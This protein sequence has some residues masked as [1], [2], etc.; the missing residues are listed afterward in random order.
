MRGAGPDRAYLCA[1]LLD[2]VSPRRTVDGAALAALNS[3]G[4]A[5]LMAIAAQHRA[6]PLMRDRLE[7]GPAVPDAVATAISSA[8]RRTALRTT[9]IARALGVIDGL[10]ADA[11]IPHR[12]LKGAY[13]AFHAYPAL[14]LRPMRDLDI[15]VPKERALEAFALLRA[16]G[17]RLSD[18]MIGDPAAMLR[19]K[20]QLPVLLSDETGIAIEVHHRL[21]HEEDLPGVRDPSADPG[22]WDDGRDRRIGGRTMRFMT[23]EAMLLHIIVHAVHDHRFDNGPHLLSDIHYLASDAAFDWANFGAMVRERGLERGVALALAATEMCW[24]PEGLVSRAGFAPPPAELALTA[25]RLTLRDADA[26]ADMALATHLSEADGAAALWRKLMP[27]RTVLEAAYAREGAPASLPHLYA[28]RLRF[29]ATKRLP[30]IL[31]RRGGAHLDQ[32]RAGLSAID[33]WLAS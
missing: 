31:D 3:D 10:L 22:F 4:W 11:D 32:E 9:R 8:T 12:P 19:I 18:P 28:R 30:A 25:A 21:F 1:L 23:A 6:W 26:S 27:S 15:L 24:G 33:R 13:L 2:W 5:A 29:L 20:H 17:H 7:A 14:G 16:H